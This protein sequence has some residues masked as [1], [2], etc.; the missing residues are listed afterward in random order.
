MYCVYFNYFV[1]YILLYKMLNNVI[2]ILIV[3]SL[4]ICCYQIYKDGEKLDEFSDLDHHGYVVKHNIIS[5]NILKTIRYYWDKGEYKKINEI[6]KSDINIKKFIQDNIKLSGYELM[7]Y[8]M[9]LE[10]TVLH[11]C[12]RDNNSQY[13]NDIKP[14][15]T[16]ILYID[17]MDRCL[18]VIP[19]SN[20]ESMG[21]Y[22]YDKTKTFICKAGSIILF[23]ASLVH[24][25]SI[26]SENNNKRIQLKVSH[27]DDLDKLSF[28][29]KYY[30]LLD[31]KNTNSNISKRIQKH[32]SC[33]F[34]IIS[35]MTQGNDKKYISGN[36]SLI[37]KI[38]SKLFYSD[39]DYYKLKDAF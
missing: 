27:S 8:I 16:M 21:M 13:F 33:R 35:D 1:F 4:L 34:P 22:W 28:Y 10:N 19:K 20:N 18:D 3:V 11:T 17:N 37:G 6:I 5:D 12:H 31:K 23:D 38:Y 24:C 15:Y 39:K 7:D 29:Q 26:G 36:M 2:V 25:G 30:K 14:S 32:F 9:F